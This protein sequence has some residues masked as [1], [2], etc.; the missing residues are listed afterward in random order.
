M[1]GNI[2]LADTAES[3]VESCTST[4]A[5]VLA[6]RAT[7]LRW[8]L[9]SITDILFI[10]LIA[11][12]AF[13]PLSD[14]L[15]NDAD[16]GWHIRDG[17]LILATHTVPRVDSFSY[18]HAG[19]PWVAW[20]WLFEVA[21]AAV[22]HYAG[23]N[24]VVLLTVIIVATTFSLLFRFLW[25]RSGNPV[26][27]MFLTVLAL[28]ASRI[29][30]LARPHVAGWLFMVLWVEALYLF[31]EGKRYALCWLPPL[32]LVWVNTHG[33]FFLG[34][35]LIVLFGCARAW[36]FQFNR[37]AENWRKLKDL[38]IAFCACLG[39]TF[40]T[41]FGIN[42]YVYVYHF[43]SSS[44]LM[45]LIGEFQ[46]PNFHWALLVYFEIFLLLLGLGLAIARERITSTDC[47]L[48]L[49]GVHVGL[50][51][52]RSV[53][54]SAILMSF[55]MAP[56][57]V[58]AIQ[59]R[60]DQPKWL[61]NAAVRCQAI[62]QDIMAIEQ[63]CRGH[64]LAVVVVIISVAIA[65]HGGRVAS[66]QVM[67]AHFSEKKFPVKAVEFMESAGIHDHFFNREEWSG[68]LIYKLYP[69]GAK[70]F[71]DDRFD[72]YGEDF[73][74]EVQTSTI[75]GEHWQVPLDKYQVKWVVIMKEIPL[76]SLLHESKAWCLRY[77]DG[78]AV[79]YERVQ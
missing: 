66:A 24:G 31:E 70:V 25:R 7:W 3:H 54:V 69:E 49:F 10:A 28:S 21:L 37:C 53:A 76:A 1:N 38:A 57:L 35:V 72:F 6:P 33:S 12:F 64:F 65:L 23:L 58:G 51:A 20:E 75:G 55:A 2:S 26:V 34:L 62:A 68:Y 40:V 59:A 61:H 48:I 18:T 77:D 73:I 71:T 67:S 5:A 11:V 19:Q 4:P 46:S 47:L 36:E 79:I 15:L 16:T 17:E 30:L 78:L 13:S 29:H 39:V 41:P 22:H 63:R 44:Y 43:L 74:K 42:L 27:A 9:P 32:M 50:Y 52:V 14:L 8:V 45:N 56:M 60:Q